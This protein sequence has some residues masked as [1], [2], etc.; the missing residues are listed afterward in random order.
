M[1]ERGATSTKGTSSSSGRPAVR[2]RDLGLTALYEPPEPIAD[3]IFVHGLQGNSRRTWCYEGPIESVE[4]SER[5]G[6]PS[7]FRF[8]RIRKSRKS[9]G[10]EKSTQSIFWPADILPK[11]H[12]NLR[13]LTFG[14]DSNVTNIGG[15][16]NKNNISQHGR[17]LL[18][19]LL[20]D[21]RR[22]DCLDRP[23][24]FVAHSV[25][26]ILVKEALNESRKQGKYDDEDDLSRIC[27][28]IVFF[29][30][31]HRGS[32]DAHLGQILSNIAGA[33]QIDTNNAILRDLDPSSGSSKLE[34]L[35]RDF[36][37]ILEEGHIRIYSFQES[38]GKT[39]LKLAGGKVVPDESSSFDS[40]KFETLVNI[41]ANHINMCRFR[42]RNDDGYG[43]FAGAMA[44]IL[45][46]IKQKSRTA[47]AEKLEAKQAEEA[48]FQEDLLRGLD[49][50]ERSVRENQVEGTNAHARTMD[51]LWNLS[52]DQNSFEQW[53]HNNDEALFWISGKP[54]SGKSTLM[55]HI[56]RDDKVLELLGS[57]TERSWVV[58]RFF[59]DFR[60]G[61]N[62]S[63]SMEGLL[64]SLLL[65]L[66]EEIPDLTPLARKSGRL[67][68][69]SDRN[70]RD[71]RE[72]LNRT[73]T[74]SPENICLLAD[75]LDEYEGDMIELL[76]FF[77]ELAAGGFNK[78]C[79]ASRPEP[80][81][82]QNL[83]TCPGFRMQDVNIQGIARYVSTTL[84]RS[85]PLTSET[86]RLKSISDD[87]AERAEGVFLWARFAIRELIEGFSGGDY[88]EELRDRLDQ[89]PPDLEQLYDRIFDRMTPE[90]RKVAS[91]MFR[92]VCF[93]HWFGRLSVQALALAADMVLGKKVRHDKILDRQTV[94]GLR[95]RIMA[96]SGG[97]LEI[98]KADSNS[99][100]CK[101]WNRDLGNGHVD[102]DGRPISSN[103]EFEY[104]YQEIR[105]AHKTIKSYLERRKWLQ[106]SVTEDIDSGTHTLWLDICCAYL[107]KVSKALDTN[108]SV[109]G[110][111]EDRTF[112]HLSER[113]WLLPYA[114][115]CIFQHARELEQVYKIST[116]D[117]IMGFIDSGCLRS[118]Q[119]QVPWALWPNSL[120]IRQSRF[121]SKWPM[122]AQTSCHGQIWSL[123]VQENLYLCY[124]DA[125]NAGRHSPQ[126][127]DIDAA[128]ATW[129]MYL[130]NKEREEFALFM[131]KHAASFTDQNILDCLHAGYVKPLKVML[132]VHPRGYLQW[133]R[134]PFVYGHPVYRCLFEKE[135]NGSNIMPLIGPLQALAMGRS[136]VDGFE[137]ILELLL[138]R[139]ED[140]NNV[141]GSQ[142]AMIH[143]LVHNSQAWYIV[144]KLTAILHRGANVNLI[145]P[146]GT[147]L[148]QA[149]NRRT[150][151]SPGLQPELQP[152]FKILID[153]GATLGWHAADGTIPT[154]EEILAWRPSYHIET[155]TSKDDEEENSEEDDSE[156]EENIEVWQQNV[157]VDPVTE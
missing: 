150:E 149:W 12:N 85:V 87:I 144:K 69:G 32:K 125:I 145:G 100:S 38:A 34:D 83:W 146:Q 5:A 73:F 24:I 82:S 101:F 90:D 13:I 9:K 111:D 99:Y 106:E 51:W 2:V 30:T 7:Q 4:H 139:G 86:E 20:T 28:G 147:P 118:L 115:N 138:D 19:A 45:K 35:R 116:F 105:L 6:S 26:G 153:Y 127:Q 76:D 122:Q 154:K 117:S 96:R 61:K 23:L 93:T 103:E 22:W 142:G 56:S 128:F 155:A 14:Y 141:C 88:L 36:S 77:R 50:V 112:R 71:L 80:V 107:E 109:S 92:L 110:I 64:R 143:V 156:D 3:V 130:D 58:I 157:N 63:N 124:K 104:H 75:G 151:E 15:L 68:C 43:K 84:Q 121:D 131:V 135:V 39:G 40:R 140:L 42:D 55:A 41:N 65:Q 62:I 8:L 27:S 119:F 21:R 78:I 136:T 129:V 114:V 95:R 91:V 29:G 89:L 94:K 134:R 37:D 98:V 17:A 57:T 137:E 33:V 31:P 16:V 47:E 10:A 60:A 11:D 54:G 44:A 81:I 46:I 48:A 67:R 52:A 66:L 132:E 148:Q 79:L 97:L 59:F 18:G 120:D 25:G 152:I 126:A 108:V 113:F 49:Y 70:Q 123:V 1:E 72:M 53:L 74:E 133:R 102:G